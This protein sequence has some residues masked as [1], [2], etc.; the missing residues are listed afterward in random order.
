MKQVCRIGLDIAKDKFQVHGVGK[1]GKDVFNKQLNR[2]NVLQFGIVFA[3]L[4]VCKVGLEA[5]A[6]C[7]YWRWQAVQEWPVPGCVPWAHPQRV[8]IRK[9]KSALI[10]TCYAF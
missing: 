10:S 2:K 7:S 3:N 6:C 1:N 5:C 9:S 4:P 8:F